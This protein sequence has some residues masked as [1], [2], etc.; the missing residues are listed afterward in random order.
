MKDNPYT[1]I[2]EMFKKTEQA[3]GIQIAEVISPPPNLVIKVNDLQIDNDNILIA[4][5]LLEKHRRKVILRGERIKF[6]KN[7]PVGQTETADSHSHGIAYIDVDN[8]VFELDAKNEPSYI[9]TE[10]TLKEGELL[11]VMPV[12]DKQL[13]IILA[14]LKEVS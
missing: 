3:P 14:R 12:S 9:Q 8:E 7:N 5:Y 2:N 6:R 11:A 1:E 10:D 13:Y 4:D